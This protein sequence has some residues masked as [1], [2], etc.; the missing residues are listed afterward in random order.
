M[1]PDDNQMD[2]IE[3]KDVTEQSF[4][5]LKPQHIQGTRSDTRSD[6][7]ILRNKQ[8]QQEEVTRNIAP[9]RK[10]YTKRKKEIVENS[11]SE[12]DDEE[13]GKSASSSLRK[14]SALIRKMYTPPNIGTK[15]KKKEKAVQTKEER[16]KLKY[17]N[18]VISCGFELGHVKGKGN[19]VNL[20]IAQELLGGKL[21]S[22]LFSA[23][24]VSLGGYNAVLSIYDTGTAGVTGAKTPIQAALAIWKV[25][26]VLTDY[27]GVAVYPYNI[28][29]VN[30]V[31]HTSLFLNVDLKALYSK[32][33]T[34]GRVASLDKTFP[35]LT[36]RLSGD[37]RG[38]KGVCAIVFD[39]GNVNIV[40][41]KTDE[42][43]RKSR[44]C[45]LPYLT[46]LIEDGCINNNKNQRKKKKNR[47]K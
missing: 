36:W 34:G 23:L 19:A 11:D 3:F 13:I 1:L 30:R 18:V 26:E 12:G 25:A 7:N 29:I 40:G 15:M 4:D 8:K 47:R 10:K 39:K 45:L 27:F 5:I 28:S 37:K 22:H 42:E 24:K 46:D 2:Y 9:C 33:I 41:I 20:L 31:T 14:W 21:D 17:A 35:G 16:A 38:K 43:Y 32:L 44:D 6:D